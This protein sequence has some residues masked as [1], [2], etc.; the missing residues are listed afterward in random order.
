[1]TINTLE[2]WHQLIKERNS[3]GLEALMAKDV[4]F[5]S[6]VVYKPQQGKALTLMYL[7]AAFNVLINDSFRYEKEIVGNQQA[8]LEF[9]VEIDGITLNG[10]DII[11]WNDQ[12]KIIEFKVMIRPLKGINLLH[13]KMAEILAAKQ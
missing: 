10:V 5:Y 4:T 11:S 2:I 13:K 3:K 9:Q 6:P 12:G 8:A 1:M 7:T